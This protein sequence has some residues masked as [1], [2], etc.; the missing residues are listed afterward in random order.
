M[1]RPAHGTGLP[2]RRPGRPPT[3][4]RRPPANPVRGRSRGFRGRPGPVRSRR[5][6]DGR[7]HQ[8]CAPRAVLQ[9]GRPGH[10][11]QRRRH[12]HRHPPGQTGPR[13]ILRCVRRHDSRMHCYGPDHPAGHRR[14]PARRRQPHRCGPDPA[15]HRRAPRW[16]DH[17]AHG[18]AHLRS[19]LLHRAGLLFLLSSQRRLPGRRAPRR[20]GSGHCA[21]GCG[22]RRH[23]PDPAGRVG[24]DRHR[25]GP[26]RCAQPRRHR[27][28]DALGPRR[29]EG[30]RSPVRGGG[31]PGLHRACQSAPA[32]RCSGG[33]LAGLA[34]RESGPA[35]REPGG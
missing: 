29:P 32:R 13:P 3:Q 7:R 33:G 20:A 4:S 19:R 2:A 10:R 34:Q 6:H 24:A 31:G 35:Q 1:G 5:R 23:R 18:R 28:A 11:P 25:P 30:F 27:A 15:G 22:L 8:R 12:R 14:L 17:L 26:A 16:M 21:H 9:R